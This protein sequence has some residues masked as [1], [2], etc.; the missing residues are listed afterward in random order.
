M[1]IGNRLKERIDTLGIKQNELAN[2]LLISVSTLNG[3]FTDYREPDIETIK[4]LAEALATTVGYLTEETDD[5]NPLHNENETIAI[6]FY[7]ENLKLL[8]PDDI[9]KVAEYAR[10]IKSQKEND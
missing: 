4:R 2:N 7:N 9:C 3:Y 6:A 5:P 8:T 1:S 10:F